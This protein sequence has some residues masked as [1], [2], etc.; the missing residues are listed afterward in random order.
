MRRMR[1]V[2]IFIVIWDP[3]GLHVKNE[4]WINYSTGLLLDHLIILAGRDLRDTC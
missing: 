2:T 1:H 4:F 3:I